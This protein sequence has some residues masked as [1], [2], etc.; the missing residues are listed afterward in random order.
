M[1]ARMFLEDTF[2]LP[3]SLSAE[4]AAAADGMNRDSALPT[5]LPTAELQR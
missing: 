2:C 4:Q 3:S 1:S 5:F